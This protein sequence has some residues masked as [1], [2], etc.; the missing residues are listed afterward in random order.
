MAGSS[1]GDI[2]LK[3]NRLVQKC[4]TRDADKIAAEL[5]IH[6]LERPF[7]KQKGAY[8][9]IERNR[10]IFLKAN[11]HPVQRSIV[12]LHE[13]G[14]DQNHR[15]EAVLAGGFREFNIFDMREDRLEYEAN[16]FASQIALPDDEVLDY[17]AQGYDIYQTAKAMY[18]DINLVALKIDTLI[19]QGY[20]LRQMERRNDFLKPDKEV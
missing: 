11:M 6:I 19:N 12:L 13:I 10:F 15:R 2:I 4:G 7:K 5:G 9:V 18:S 14:H 16:I 17:I 20:T 8:L 1:T 3:A